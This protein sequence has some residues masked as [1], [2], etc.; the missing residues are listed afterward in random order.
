MKNLFLWYIPQAALFALGFW[1]A[2]TIEP[3]TTV[4]AMV[5]FGVMLAAAYTGAVNLILSGLSALRRRLRRDCGQSGGDSLS[6]VRPRSRL[7]KAPKKRERVGVR[8]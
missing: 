1:F 4:L 3:P 7:S 8:D 5:V 2:T 6:L